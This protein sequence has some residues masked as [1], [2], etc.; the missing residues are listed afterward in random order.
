[1]EHPV[2]LDIRE[3]AQ[4]VAGACARGDAV[5]Q[6]LDLVLALDAERPQAGHQLAHR[7]M[8]QHAGVEPGGGLDDQTDE[9]GE[10]A[11]DPWARAQVAAPGQVVVD[12]PHG[13]R[14]ARDIPVTLQRGRYAY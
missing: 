12:R 10:G 13:A 1:M 6:A 8:A 11:V 5:C 2:V 4:L 3:A 7:R 14:G 9:A